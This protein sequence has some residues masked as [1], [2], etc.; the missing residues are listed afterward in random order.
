[1]KVLLAGGGSGGHV[2][3]LKAILKSLK[4]TTNEPLKVTVVVDRGF[5]PQTKFLFSDDKKIR[6]KKIFSG[7]LRRYNTKSLAWHLFHLP[8]VLKNLRDVF[9]IIIGTFQMFIHF[10]F[11][12]P[13]VVF[14]KGGFVCIPVGFMAYMFK[15]PLVIHDSDT[16]PGLTNRILARW[17]EII[18]TGMPAK[19]YSYPKN[20]MVYTGIPVDPAIKP[21]SKEVQATA[22]SELGFDPARH[23]VLVTGGGTG[24]KTLN[25][26][27]LTNLIELLESGLQVSLITGKGKGREAQTA[28]E[29][30]PAGYRK[31][32]Q[33][34]EFTS[35]LPQILA[36]DVVVSRAGATAMQEFANAGK[37]VVVVP[38][39]YLTGGHQLKNAE[40]F[41]EQ[42]SVVM[43]LELELAKPGKLL[44][45][46]SKAK[47]DTTLGKKL[48]DNFAKPHASDEL[49]KIVIGK[50]EEQRAE[51]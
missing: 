3:P 40:M 18:A 19:Y 36:A 20:K 16:H 31:N 2:T 4:E 24:A 9:Y 22:K 23:L 27:L 42:G 38:N 26:A 33:Y 49:A 13:D 6:L 44:E 41:A 29:S 14:A 32:F 28:R 46:I 30:L 15:V 50:V 43:L 10:I 48:K 34:Q 39:P 12:K 25:D 8:T 37:K 17:A 51:S 1:M 35:M 5:Y 21:A 45:A 7:K 47:E 11:H